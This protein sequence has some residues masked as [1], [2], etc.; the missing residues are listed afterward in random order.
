METIHLED[1]HQD[2][3]RIIGDAGVISSTEPFNQGWLVGREYI[4]DGN[5]LFFRDGDYGN[6]LKHLVEKVVKN[7]N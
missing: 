6:P 2:F 7:I 3:L 1:N 4:I 5:I